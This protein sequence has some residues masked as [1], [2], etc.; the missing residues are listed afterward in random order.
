MATAVPRF[1]S[2]RP[3]SISYAPRRRL[4]FVMLLFCETIDARL[5]LAMSMSRA[6]TQAPFLF[7]EGVA[8][9]RIVSALFRVGS[10]Q[11]VAF[12]VVGVRVLTHFELILA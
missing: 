2:E 9:M 3:L 8:A 4:E 12:L 5:R 6:I 7:V 11:T 10:C 1:A